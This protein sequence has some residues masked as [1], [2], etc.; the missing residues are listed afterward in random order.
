MYNAS[1]VQ[2]KGNDLQ[3]YNS[4]VYFHFL[5]AKYVYLYNSYISQS[6]TYQLIL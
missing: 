5:P 1:I 4:S 2:L 6:A 3:I